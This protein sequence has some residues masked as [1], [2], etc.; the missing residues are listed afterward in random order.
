M[1]AN[2][3]GT[4]RRVGRPF[5]QGNKA[6]VGTR[7]IITLREKRRILKALKA[8]ALGG[9]GRAAVALAHMGVDF[10]VP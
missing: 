2:E 6:A 4:K 5:Q 9:D 7:E 3:A 1:N 10:G 8:Q